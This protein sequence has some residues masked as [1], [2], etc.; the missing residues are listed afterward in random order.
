MEGYPIPLLTMRTGKG[1]YT[2]EEIKELSG[3]FWLGGEGERDWKVSILQLPFLF[4]RLQGDVCY[5]SE[6]KIS[7]KDI[8][9]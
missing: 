4:P 7:D 6:D 2:K 3:C 9:Y 5:I 8:G 1:R